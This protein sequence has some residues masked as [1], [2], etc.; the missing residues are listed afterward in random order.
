MYHSRII[1][2][3]FHISN[4]IIHSLEECENIAVQVHTSKVPHNENNAT[5][6]I[7]NVNDGLQTLLTMASPTNTL[8]KFVLNAL[9][10]LQKKLLT[11]QSG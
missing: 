4:L 5:H 6:R 11:R 10:A 9:C 8:A 1:Q 7:I 2:R 3:L